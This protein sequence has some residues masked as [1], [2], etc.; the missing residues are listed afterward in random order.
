MEHKHVFI[1]RTLNSSVMLEI[2]ALIKLRDYT[3]IYS[4]DLRGKCYWI[5]YIYLD[6]LRS[7]RVW[8]KTYTWADAEN[9]LF[10]TVVFYGFIYGLWRSSCLIKRCTS[11]LFDFNKHLF[12][13]LPEWQGSTSQIAAW[14]TPRGRSPQNKWAGED[15]KIT[16]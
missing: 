15:L 12:S 7:K 9:G 11:H 10:M 4:V 5:T 13:W 8:N 1:K 16:I 3:F 6:Y 2:S 14:Q